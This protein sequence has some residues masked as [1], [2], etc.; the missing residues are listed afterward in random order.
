M[1]ENT[2][3][4]MA[5]GDHLTVKI[6]LLGEGAVGKTSLVTRYVKNTFNNQHVMTL[7]VVPLR[8]FKGCLL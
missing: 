8:H 2:N 6:V 4:A 1:E 3:F 5:E 7:Q